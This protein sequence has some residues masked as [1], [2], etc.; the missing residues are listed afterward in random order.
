MNTSTNFVVRAH[1]L[2]SE[3]QMFFKQRQEL[4]AFEIGFA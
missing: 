4:V 1:A 2:L 3:L